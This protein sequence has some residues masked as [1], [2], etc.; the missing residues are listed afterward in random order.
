MNRKTLAVTFGA[1]A[2][3]TLATPAAQAA[4]GLALAGALPVGDV[5]GQAAPVA[6]SV[7]GA[8]PVAD[9]AQKAGDPV[10]GLLGGLPLNG[11][12]LSGLPVSGLPVSGLPLG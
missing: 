11:L 12:P 6:E 7:T 3:A 2:A 10:A 4:D 9:Q 8:A 5:V 1:L